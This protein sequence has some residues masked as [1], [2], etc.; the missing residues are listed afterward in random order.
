MASTDVFTVNSNT[1]WQTTSGATWLTVTN[2][3]ILS[4]T[5]TVIVTA[6]SMN[7]APLPRASFVAVQDVAGTIFDTLFVFQAGT[8]PI[9]IGA[10]DTVLLG[11]IT[12]S[13][14]VLNIG[15]TGSWTGIEGNPWFSMSQNSGSG[16]TTINL[17]T[18]SANTGTTR[19]VS[20]VALA[21]AANNLTDSII[22]I[23]DTLTVG[24]AASPDTVRVGAAVGSS[25]TF[26]VS[27]S[28]SWTA[29]ASATWITVTP[30]NGN[31]SASVSV[32]A[33]ANPRTTERLSFIEV[34]TTGGAI[35]IDTVWV[36]QEGFVASLVVNP[37]TINLGFL[38]NSNETASI[39]SNT[40]WV[41]TNPAS[42]LSVSSTSGIND[43]ILT[44]STTSDNLTGATRTATLL[45]DGIGA[46]TQ[47]ITVN[48]VD[49]SS[50]IFISSKDTVFVDNLQ[51]STGSFSV[52]SNANSWT[53]TENTSWM[54]INPTSGSQTQ[55]VTALAATRNI[56][57]TTRYAN[58]TASSNGFSNFTVV[59]AQK[60]SNPIF[61]VAP[62]SILIGADSSDFKEFNISSNM[63]VWSISENAT[64]LRI[65][66][67]NGA[68]TQSVRATVSS[69]NN[70]GV[71]RSAIATITAPPLV[72]QI[73][74]IV[75]D[76]IRTIGIGNNSLEIGLNV[77]PNPTT[78]LVAIEFGAQA[79][80]ELAAVRLFNLLGE[81]IP[82]SIT[83]SA[84][85]KLHL[86]LKNLNSG[87]YFFSI[88]LNGET[89]NKKLILT[90]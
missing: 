69:Q 81:Q 41:I 5:Q 58:I 42:W 11:A 60:E 7:M 55:T 64:W 62:D 46:I 53:V 71:Q 84:K 79:N 28:Q 35:N 76:T 36:I 66:P 61:Q 80:V 15:S 56:F 44:I 47:T 25:S 29:T 45:V 23:Q 43:Q 10:P 78:G 13:S 18:N 85:N 8:T 73:I 77:Y 22:V 82:I 59:V 88:Q 87:I 33:D 26:T 4:D 50:P 30:A 72:P 90:E 40:S 70:T 38:A 48:Q 20:Y 2:P 27:A 75:Q 14:E 65:S 49:G 3:A 86:N 54:L 31:G 17:T 32:S 19:L 67:E 74:R 21:D 63:P 9:L 16:I 34:S 12:G 6:N 24:L 52:L 51:G 57:G 39:V 83:F 68:F 37:S 89:I 1:T